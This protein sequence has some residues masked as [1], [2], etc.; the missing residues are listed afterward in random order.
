MIPTFLSSVAAQ[1]EQKWQKV[2]LADPHAY[3]LVQRGTRE[4]ARAAWSHICCGL[5]LDFPLRDRY[6]RELEAM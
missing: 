1:V 6:R 4:G 2:M 5:R 3:W